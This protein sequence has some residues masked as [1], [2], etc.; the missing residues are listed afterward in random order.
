MQHQN[1]GLGRDEEL[2]FVFVD[3]HSSAGE[4]FFVWEVALLHWVF[5]LRRFEAV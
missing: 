2:F 3:F 5:G 1:A 4:V